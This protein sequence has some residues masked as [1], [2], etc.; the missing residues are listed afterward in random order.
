M[1]FNFGMKCKSENTSTQIVTVYNGVAVPPT[2]F[3]TP[4]DD[5]V[6]RNML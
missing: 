1:E 5:R 6:D 3:N 2:N 4:E